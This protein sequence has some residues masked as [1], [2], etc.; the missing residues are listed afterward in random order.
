MRIS[1]WSS[2]VCSS[3]LA[4]AGQRADARRALVVD[5]VVRIAAG[6][7]RRAALVGEARQ[8]QPG[9]EVDEHVLE[10]SDVAVGRADRLADGL[11]R[12][13]SDAERPAEQR[14]AVPAPE[15]GCVL[16][17]QVAS[18]EERRVGREAVS[19]VSPRGMPAQYNKK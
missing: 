15:I 9:A 13:A 18:T 3:D 16:Q 7:D 8:L 6:I 11:A 1:D 4:P 14:G 17:H 12:P 5:D 10:R 2:D 19:T